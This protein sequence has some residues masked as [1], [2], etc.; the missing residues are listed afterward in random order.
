ME[1]A[2][3]GE[4]DWKAAT[5]LEGKV[6]VMTG[7]ASGIGRAAA[8]QFASAGAAVVG[9]DI[10]VEG[11]HNTAKEIAA[12]GGR[13]ESIALDLS[14]GDSVDRFAD[15]A[16]RRCGV[17]DVIASVAGWDKI[18]PFLDNDPALWEQLT[19]INFMG[20][21]RLVHRL[22]PAMIER[23]AGGRVLTVASDAGRVGSM[24]ETFYAG[25][26]GAVIAFTKSLARE[27]ARHRINCNTVCPGPTDTPL[28]ASIESEKLRNALVSAIP[29]RRLA[30][31]V[32]IA[33]AI[34]F[35]CTPAAD[36]ITGQV[37]SVSGGLT[38]HG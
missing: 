26:K 38:M 25:T 18:G 1:M 22:L 2:M 13:A 28:F 17:P 5:S 37:L 19:R 23:N 6:V 29:L 35:L 8:L 36:F 15:E 10:N 14:D 12:R 27:M 31:P 30:R 33:N 9:G 16:I 32:E 21:V 20:P 24:G 3:Q 34:V 11:A 7:V 4:L